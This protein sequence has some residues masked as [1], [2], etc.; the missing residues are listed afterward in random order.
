MHAIGFGSAG[1][2]GG[3]AGKGK[4][5]KIQ[6]FLTIEDIQLLGVVIR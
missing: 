5:K 6:L 3:G 4:Q 1:D 2:L